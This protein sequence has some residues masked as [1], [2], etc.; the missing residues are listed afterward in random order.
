M[1]HRFTPAIACSTLTRRRASL[2]FARFSAAVSS[3]RG[4]FFF[5]LAGFLHRWFVPLKA[6]IL[7]QHG[8]GWVGVAFP[9]GNR[10]VGCLAGVGA[11]QE[12]DAFTLDLGDHHVLV[13]VR[14]LP[15][16]VVAGLFFRVFRPLATPLRAVDDEPGAR[17]GSW[18]ALGKVTGAP[19]G[20]DAEIVKSDLQDRQQPLNPMIRLGLTQAKEFADDDL[21]RVGLE[22]GQDEQELLLG[23][24]Q[25][26]LPTTARRTLAGLA[27]DGLARWVQPLIGPGESRQQLPELRHRQSRDGQELPPV[28]LELRVCHHTAIVR[29]F[30]IPDN[31]SYEVICV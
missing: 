13:A 30:L 14:L 23:P 7:V 1:R 22:V 12:A 27:F 8:P 31:V 17:F 19:L 24:M 20:P 26:P 5:R 2:R 6:R 28:A 10:L 25:Q 3:P 9:A 18:V 21:Q 29:G 16:A 4:G 15:A 11:A